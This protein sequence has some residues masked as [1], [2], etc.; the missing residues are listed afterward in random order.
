MKILRN[1]SLFI[2]L[3]CVILLT[4]VACV[5]PHEVIFLNDSCIIPFKRYDY[6]TCQSMRLTIDGERYVVPKNFTTDLAS[7]P[8]PLWS[9]IAPQYTG[10]VAPAIL[11]DFLYSCPHNITRSYADEVLYS[12][13]L[14]E[15]VSHYTAIK[16]YMAVRLF[17]ASHF[18]NKNCNKLG[19]ESWTTYPPY[20]Q[21]LSSMKA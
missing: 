17:G 14:T 4:E 15:G 18:N 5:K 3:C 1:V 6:H 16:F 19:A 7:I 10:F 13:L 20:A 9:F 12:A 2:I 11:H 8:R 21:E